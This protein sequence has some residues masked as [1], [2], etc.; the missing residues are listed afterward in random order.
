MTCALIPESIACLVSVCLF[1]TAIDMMK[2]G[3]FLLHHTAKLAATYYFYLLIEGV[4]DNNASVRH[5][6]HFLSENT[7]TVKSSSFSFLS[8]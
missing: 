6:V 7:F 8:I 2:S 1:I 3:L 5:G 4:I